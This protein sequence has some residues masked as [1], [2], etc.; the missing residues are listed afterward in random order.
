[1]R[2]E[3]DVKIRNKKRTRYFSRKTSKTAEYLLHFRYI[4]TFSPYVDI[5]INEQ[6]GYFE[7]HVI[8]KPSYYISV[9]G[10][11]RKEVVTQL[12][13]E[14]KDSHFT[15]VFNSKFFTIVDFVINNTL[16]T[17]AERRK[18]IEFVEKYNKEYHNITI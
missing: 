17:K 4:L 16:Y 15:W 8:G 7:S 14:L 5:I 11:D 6:T 12:F 3:P 13:E 2:S 1:M 9:I 10:K 18:S